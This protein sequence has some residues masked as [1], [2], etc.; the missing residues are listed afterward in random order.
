MSIHT[1]KY[2]ECS[3]HKCDGI[4]LVDVETEK[5][6]RTDKQGNNFYYCP[7]GPHVFAVPTD[8]EVTD[9]T[10]KTVTLTR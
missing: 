9:R 5:T 6:P 3:Q 8:G 10:R 4:L 2:H 7:E 1:K